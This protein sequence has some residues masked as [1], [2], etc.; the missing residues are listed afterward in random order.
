MLQLLETE[1]T[2]NLQGDSFYTVAYADPMTKTNKIEMAK[3][4][5][6]LGLEAIKIN[7]IQ[8]YYKKKT[9]NTRGS[10]KPSKVMVKRSRK[11]MIKF[12]TGQVLTKDIMEEANKVLGYNVPKTETVNN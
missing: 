2:Y 5:K 3:L 4:F 7:S 6:K 1:K 12:K 11:F 9:K 8:P 10:R